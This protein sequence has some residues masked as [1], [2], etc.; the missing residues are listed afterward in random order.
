M[1]VQTLAKFCQ[2]IEDRLHRVVIALSTTTSLS[3]V[4]PALSEHVFHSIT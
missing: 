4:G 3:L 2:S 1:R